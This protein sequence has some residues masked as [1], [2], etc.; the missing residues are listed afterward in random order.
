LV[1]VSILKS[2]TVK[3]FRFASLIPFGVKMA[4]RDEEEKVAVADRLAMLDGFSRIAYRFGKIVG[5]T[6]S[7]TV[8]A[9]T[10]KRPVTSV[11][12]VI[13]FLQSIGAYSWETGRSSLQIAKNLGL[14]QITVSKAVQKLQDRGLI[15]AEKRGKSIRYYLPRRP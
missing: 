14:A 6:G 7:A 13:E 12:T 4:F 15:K 10:A 2:L 11:D 1:Y 9:V 3:A 8:R 5:L